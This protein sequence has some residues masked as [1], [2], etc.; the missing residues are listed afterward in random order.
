MGSYGRQ[1]EVFSIYDKRNVNV[2]PLSAYLFHFLVT[3]LTL[4]APTPQND[5]THS[6][7][8]SAKAGE[9]FECIWPFCGVGAQ[10]VQT[11]LSI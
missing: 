4:Q 5:Q 11:M 1:S 8:L 3:L 2:L 9:L 6:Y 10:R 7:N